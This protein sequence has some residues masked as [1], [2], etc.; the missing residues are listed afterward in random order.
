MDSASCQLKAISTLSFADKILL[1]EPT[2]LPGPWSRTG[3]IVRTRRGWGQMQLPFG[4][5]VALP[6]LSTGWVPR[7]R[8][9]RSGHGGASS[10]HSTDFPTPEFP[11][12][13]KNNLLASPRAKC[14]LSLAG[15]RHRLR[16]MGGDT[17][18]GWR[19]S[20]RAGVKGT[21]GAQPGPSG[22]GSV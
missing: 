20:Q 17:V 2:I 14:P 16:C 18:T 21:P 8:A 12:L 15:D 22:W 5:T 10:G 4:P 11:L 13:R 7:G 3:L 1:G 19:C 9:G 6:A